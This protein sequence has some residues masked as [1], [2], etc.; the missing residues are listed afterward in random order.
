MDAGSVRPRYNFLKRRSENPRGI[1]PRQ[2]CRIQSLLVCMVILLTY[3][4]VLSTR[5]G[6]SVVDD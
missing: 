2:F 5:P 4:Y 1:D 6:L 3:K